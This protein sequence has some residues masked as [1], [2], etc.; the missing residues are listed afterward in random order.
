MH[1]RYLSVQEAVAFNVAVIKRYREIEF[2]QLSSPGLSTIN[3]A[4]NPLH[5]SGLMSVL[6]LV[7]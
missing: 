1:I 6:I 3:T 4:K 7:Y 2:K 5:M